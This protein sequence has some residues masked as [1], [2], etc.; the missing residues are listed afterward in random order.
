MM[1]AFPK[2]GARQAVRQG[3]MVAALALLA[4]CGGEVGGF[5]V[6]DLRGALPNDPLNPGAGGGAVAVGAP[7]AGGVVTDAFAGQGTRDPLAGGIGTTP[8]G[9]VMANPG[10]PTPPVTGSGNTVTAAAPAAAVPAAAA[11]SHT[12]VA[13]ETAYSVARKYGISVQQLAAAN[14]LSEAAAIRI[15]QR[16][17]IPAAGAAVAATVTAPGVGS[18]TPV[19]PSASA[20]LPRDNPQRANAPVNAPQTDLGSTR[21]AASSGRLAMP[22][23]GSVVRAYKKGSNDGIDIAA[24]AGSAV[25]AAGAGTV[26]AITKDTGQVPIVVVRHSNGLMTVYANIDGVAVK[27]GD[28]VSAGQTLGKARSGPVHFEVRKGFDSVDPANY[29]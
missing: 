22:A 14:G 15:G 25:K 29:L 1:K 11:Q 24:P 2:M 26:A 20:P 7:A 23:Q 18:P 5:P 4:G 10:A 19:P 13:G 3:M 8:G 28:S 16:L 17:T 12:V 27:K 21:T 6:P 9:V